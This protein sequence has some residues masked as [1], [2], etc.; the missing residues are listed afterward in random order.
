MRGDLF[1]YDERRGLVCFESSSDERS[2]LR[3][4]SA[5]LAY[6]KNI[7]ILIPGITEG[8][9]A[10]PYT[11]ALKSLAHEVGYSLL[12]PILRSSWES[13]GNYTI[14]SDVEDLTTLLHFLYAR[15]RDD[16]SRDA[17]H[18]DDLNV[19]FLGH[20]TGCQ[21]TLLLM[22]HISN[23]SVLTKMIKGVILQAAVSDRQF[24]DFK[25][26]RLSHWLSLANDMVH[27]GKGQEFMPRESYFVPIIAARYC[28]LANYGGKEDLFSTDLTA[29]YLKGFYAVMNPK[30]PILVFCSE[31]DQY[32]PPTISKSDIE[33][34]FAKDIC[35]QLE[36]SWI[37]KADHNL[38]LLT[39]K[40]LH[41]FFLSK[42]STFLCRR[43]TQ[44]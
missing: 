8:P 44:S 17:I 39:Q 6:P 1:Q 7:L 4:T 19:V 11:D 34:V 23:N 41:Q 14:D 2:A 5:P 20:S 33:K 12:Q 18:G 15:N 30:V 24:M 22:S 21:I 29:E 16:E 36:F 10:L 27:A 37:P 25:S 9:L 13:F 26:P 28:S 32:V 38:S 42:V 43:F 31:E 35:Q 40:D 3:V